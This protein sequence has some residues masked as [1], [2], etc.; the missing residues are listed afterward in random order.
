[1]ILDPEEEED[2]SS[3]YFDSTTRTPEI[4]DGPRFLNQGDLVEL[5]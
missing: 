4:L 2:E 1:M 5:L 3:L